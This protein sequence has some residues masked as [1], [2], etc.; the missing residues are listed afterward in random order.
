MQTVCWHIIKDCFLLPD[1]HELIRGY[2]AMH[3]HV[4]GKTF[5]SPTFFLPPHNESAIGKS[6]NMLQPCT[7]QVSRLPEQENL[8]FWLLVLFSQKT[9]S[10]HTV[11]GCTASRGL[12]QLGN[13]KHEFFRSSLDVKF[14]HVPARQRRA[15]AT[16]ILRIGSWNPCIC[17]HN[18]FSGCGEKFTLTFNSG[19][20]SLNFK[21][22]ISEF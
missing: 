17:A 2:R 4:V 14:T 5:F 12:S 22:N 15:A 8:A 10:K 9:P 13:E 19:K 1:W 18:V 3:T 11:P 21:N 6:G 7:H 16:F 20:S